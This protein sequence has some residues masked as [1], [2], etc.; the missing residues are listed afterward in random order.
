MT[1]VMIAFH[2]QIEDQIRIGV[3]TA[4]GIHMNSA[5]PELEKRLDE[6]LEQRK[7]PLSREEDNFR[8]ACRDMMRIGAYKP[9]G[10]G[11]PSSEYLLR[12]AGEEDFPR[13]NA[14]TDIN[15]YVS[16]KYLTPISLWD[17]DKIEATSWLFRPGNDDESFVFNKSGQTIDLK[18]LITGFA[19]TE[20]REEPVATPVKDC[21]KTK[22]DAST[23]NLAVAI[24]Y[25]AG[26][27][28]QPALSSI[29]DEFSELLDC[30]SE[31]VENRQ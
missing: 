13:I 25:P 7:Q 8:K 3:I 28:G 23:R 22:T 26:W 1:P 9:T 4:N 10:R 17:L 31:K 29:I 18:D 11:K 21:Q 5:N 27:E 15:N 14:V 6:I 19:I 30:I 24:Y 2:N 16:L 12:A 20:T